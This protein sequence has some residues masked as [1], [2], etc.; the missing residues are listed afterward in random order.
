[1]YCA[2]TPDG[3]RMGVQ[4]STPLAGFHLLEY[5]IESHPRGS[6]AHIP[7]SK[8]G[9][10]GGVEGRTNVLLILSRTCFIYIET[11]G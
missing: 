4:V 1:M 5:E 8:R 2:G 9:P 10:E 11:K 7:I 3:Y 6:A